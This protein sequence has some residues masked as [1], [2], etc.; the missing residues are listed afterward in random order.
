MSGGR[1]AS[2]RSMCDHSA[3]AELPPT[4]SWRTQPGRMPYSPKVRSLSSGLPLRKNFWSSASTPVHSCSCAFSQDSV[5][6]SAKPTARRWPLGM[7]TV[8]TLAAT[9]WPGSTFIRNRVRCRMPCA[10]R[11]ASLG[12][13]SSSPPKERLW[14]CAGA[15][16][17]WGIPRILLKR[18]R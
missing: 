12:R 8:R 7:R 15:S 16:E 2:R 17:T 9:S 5:R 11:L 13:P 3:E 1:P 6:S 10:R 14:R 4:T 18:Y